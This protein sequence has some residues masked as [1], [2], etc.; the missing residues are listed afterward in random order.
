MRTGD[1]EPRGAQTLG[2]LP[3]RCMGPEGVGVVLPPASCN[4]LILGKRVPSLVPGPK[5]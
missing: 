2:D 1:L 4:G 3:H 5:Y